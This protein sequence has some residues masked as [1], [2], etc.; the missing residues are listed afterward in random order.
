M[1]DRAVDVDVVARPEG[2]RAEHA[3]QRALAVHQALELHPLLEDAEDQLLLL[4]AG[5]IGD[6]LGFGGGDQDQQRM[7]GLRAGPNTRIDLGY[8]YLHDRRTTDRGLPSQNGRP[9]EGFDRTYEDPAHDTPEARRLYYGDAEHLRWYGRDVRDRFAAP[10]FFGFL[11]QTLRRTDRMLINFL[12]A[13]SEAAP[14]NQFGFWEAMEQGGV[15]AWSIFG[16]LVIMSVFSFYI[17]IT[18]LLEQNKIMRQYKAVQSSF[19]RANT[20]SE[21]ATKLEKNS[22]WRQL[23]LPHDGVLLDQVEDL[24]V[25]VL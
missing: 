10:G 19:W 12:A 4:Q 9:I 13:A 6:L 25:G 5:D 21:G 14:V 1:R 20:I 7:L 17:L 18:K 16:V 24:G 22:A 11:V 8:E 2:H 3:F 15:I 23:D